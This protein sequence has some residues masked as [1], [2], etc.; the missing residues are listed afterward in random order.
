VNAPILFCRE[1][2][3][4]DWQVIVVAVDELEREHFD[5]PS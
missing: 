1:Y 4:P 2:V 3:L 5:F